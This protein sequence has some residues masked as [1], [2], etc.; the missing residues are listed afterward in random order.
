MDSDKPQMRKFETQL[1]KCHERQLHV[2][3][4]SRGIKYK[5]KFFQRIFSSLH[6]EVNKALRAVFQWNQN[7][8]KLKAVKLLLTILKM[9][10]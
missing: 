8:N 2:L 4:H 7:T 1:G 10:A 9:Y 5:N 3:M 6:N